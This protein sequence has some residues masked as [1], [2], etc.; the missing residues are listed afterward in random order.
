MSKVLKQEFK[1]KILDSSN[2]ELQARLAAASGK[3]I[4]SIVRWVKG[5]NDSLE[6]MSIVKVLQEEF[7]IADA[8]NLFEQTETEP[9]A[10][11]RHEKTAA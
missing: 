4:Q 10:T 5:D 8:E 9:E 6:R 7:G 11:I 1:Q 3:S 2:V